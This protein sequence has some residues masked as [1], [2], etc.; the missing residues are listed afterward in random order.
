M[1]V[2]FVRSNKINFCLTFICRHDYWHVHQVLLHTSLVIQYCYPECEAR[3]KPTRY[4][5][6]TFNKYNICGFPFS[7]RIEGGGAK[8]RRDCSEAKMWHRQEIGVRKTGIDEVTIPSSKNFWQ[9]NN[10]KYFS[11]NLTN[12]K[13]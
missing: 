8:F 13:P 5:H 10:L 12:L 11:S 4:S 1:K 6:F 2:F 7:M 9:H 3:K